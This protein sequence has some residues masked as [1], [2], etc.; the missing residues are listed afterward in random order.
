M[1]DKHVDSLSSKVLSLE[2]L[3]FRILLFSSHN[4]VVDTVGWLSSS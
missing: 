2:G 1:E 3:Y 4:Q